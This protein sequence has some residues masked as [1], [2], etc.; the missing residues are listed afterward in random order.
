[1]LEYC[2][3]D[4]V[5]VANETEDAA[6]GKG[7]YEHPLDA[8]AGRVLTNAERG[9]GK[10][11]STPEAEQPKQLEENEAQSKQAKKAG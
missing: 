7:W 9:S 2:C 11:S 1:M 10:W 8:Q 3:G 4:P 5:L 6:L